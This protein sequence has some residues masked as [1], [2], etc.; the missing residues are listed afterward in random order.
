M[1]RPGREAH[2]SPPSTVKIGWSHI[3]TPACAFKRKGKTKQSKELTKLI[4]QI[5]QEKK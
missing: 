1:K 5:D 3:S 4:N 2:C